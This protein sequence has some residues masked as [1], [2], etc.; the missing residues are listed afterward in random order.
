MAEPEDPILT[1]LDSI[2]VGYT[3]SDGGYFE[4][5]WVSFQYNS[6]NAGSIDVQVHYNEDC[7]VFTI[8]AM[9]RDDLDAKNYDEVLWLA[10]KANL[11]SRF[12]YMVVGDVQDEKFYFWCTCSNAADDGPGDN[13]IDAMIRNTCD[14]VALYYP[15]VMKINWAGITGSEALDSLY[16]DNDDTDKGTPPPPLDGYQ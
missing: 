7:T 13:A 5:E 15:A 14:M 9:K 11:L 16:P 12:S 3:K 2:G 10:N 1:Y 4:Y 8:I 6:E